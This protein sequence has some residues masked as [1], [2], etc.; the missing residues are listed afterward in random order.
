MRPKHLIYAIGDGDG[1]DVIINTQEKTVTI[2][3]AGQK[4]V[5]DLSETRDFSLVSEMISKSNPAVASPPQRPIVHNPPAQPGPASPPATPMVATIEGKDRATASMWVVRFEGK[6][7]RQSGEA[8]Q[9]NKPDQ[10]IRNAQFF[11]S[12]EAALPVAQMFPGSEIKLFSDVADY[13][14]IFVAPDN[15][16]SFF[17]GNGQP[18]S[19]HVSNAMIGSTRG[20]AINTLSTAQVP[21]GYRAFLLPDV[22]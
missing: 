1:T 10:P 22:A 18:P 15:K 20:A 4:M 12:P 21:A 13:Y 9:I 17:C 3:K 2:D 14:I 16:M 19:H 11:D 7:F 8:G 5:L 6:Y